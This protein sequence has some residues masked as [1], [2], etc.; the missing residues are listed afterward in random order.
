MTSFEL[1]ER[2][3][4]ALAIGLLVGVERGWQE[5]DAKDGAR[6][7][8]TR[9]Y[10]LIGLLGG[11]AAALQP[12][13]GNL[14][15]AAIALGFAGGFAAFALREARLGGVA[16]ATNLVAGIVT[17]ALGAVAVA[18]SMLVA[19]VTGVAVTVILAE[20][21]S[22]HAF[23]GR[24]TWEELRSALLLIAMVFVMLPILP[25]RTVDPWQSLNPRQLWLMM[26]V[27][28]AISYAGYIC[29]RLLGERA[30]IVL[31]AAVGGLVSS[32]AVT[33]AYSRLS[34]L[35]PQN[36][37][38]LAAGISSSWTVSLLRMCAIAGAICPPIIVP[39]A[40]SFGPPIVAL[41]LFSAVFYRRAGG[42]D[43]GSPLL[44]TDPF[45][46]G[47]VLK[48]GVLLAAVS[49]ASKLA[50]QYVGALSFFPLAAVTGLV[51]VDPIT[52]SVAKIAGPGLSLV[53]AAHVI[54]T[55]AAANLL[56]KTGVVVVLGAR[57]LMSKLV[58]AA[59]LAAAVGAVAF[60]LA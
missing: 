32:T 24:L 40:W 28:A 50:R 19:G 57:S 26:V 35:H 38:A 42:G 21:K 5:R 36:A 48:F 18:G 58:L 7:A 39:L 8:G 56:C 9:T 27:I 43:K 47:E 60:V 15:V 25:D 6:A 2:L 13:L 41:T 46:L 10:A 53:D 3:G 16:S 4:L 49:V 52:I 45:E 20:R 33:L 55:A 51:D 12:I 14:A 11:V 30:G 44:L 23:V 1:L 17:F 29:V 34:K 59:G 37:P 54:L 31:A 22:I